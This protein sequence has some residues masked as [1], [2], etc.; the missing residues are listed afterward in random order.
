MLSLKLYDYTYKRSSTYYFQKD[1]QTWEEYARTSNKNGR[2]QAIFKPDNID[3]H[4][5]IKS[6]NANPKRVIS[7]WTDYMRDVVFRLLLCLQISDKRSYSACFESKEEEKITKINGWQ[8][9]V[10]EM[11][12]LGV[13]S[14]TGRLGTV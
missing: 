14:Q 8:M 11:S 5:Q 9:S 4:L 1:K 7:N 10:T 13:S 3:Y 2:A 12:Q 6:D